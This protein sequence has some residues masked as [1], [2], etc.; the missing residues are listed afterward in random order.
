MTQRIACG[1]GAHRSQA[2]ASATA[3]VRRGDLV[4][5]PTETVYALAAD[6]FSA[7]GVAALREAKGYDEATPLPVMVGKRST[8][9]GIAARLTDDA[10]VLME[11]FWPGPLTLLLTAQ[12]SLAWDQPADAP[13]AV[14]MP[15]HPVA[16]AVLTAT[17]PLVVTAANLPGLPA[18]VTVDDALAQM[19][20]DCALALDA[21]PL[22]GGTH[23]AS[24]VVD[25]SAVP[26][27]I[28]RPGALTASQIRECCPSVIEGDDAITP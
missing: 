15:L 28:L 5:L 16:L 20:D 26:P 18:P 19:G 4:L 2:V 14:R 11:G 1:D 7:R 23:G 6:A 12:P 9:P 8:V 10:R 27:R 24:T 3:A 22:P 25:A 13:V 17:G 21:G